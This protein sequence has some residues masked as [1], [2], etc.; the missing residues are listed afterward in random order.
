MGW[1][2]HGDVDAQRLFA[3]HVLARFNGLDGLLGVHRRCGC[4]HHCFQSYMHQQAGASLESR[5]IPS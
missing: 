3:E 4:Y 2:Y 5:R 1:K